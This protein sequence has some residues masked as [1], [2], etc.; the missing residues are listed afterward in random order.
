MAWTDPTTDAALLDV[1][2]KDRPKDDGVLAVYLDG[3]HVQ[4]V[5]YL[6]ADPEA[7][8]TANY[9]LAEIYQARALQRAGWVGTGDQAGMDGFGVTVY[10]MDWNVKRLLRPEAARMVVR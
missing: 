6:G 4:C 2:W 3:A 10:P 5:A 1:A 7:A 8:V 9:K